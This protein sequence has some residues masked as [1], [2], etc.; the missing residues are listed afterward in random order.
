MCFTL[1]AYLPLPYLSASR[2]APPL[3]HNDAR[4]SALLRIFEIAVV[5]RSCSVGGRVHNTVFFRGSDAGAQL[6]F[7]GSHMPDRETLI[8]ENSQDYWTLRVAGS[9]LP[10]SYSHVLTDPIGASIAEIVSAFP[11]CGG[12]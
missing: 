4:V 5:T 1:G 8:A 12:L 10:I 2:S 11:T 9:G 3:S 6:P 7:S